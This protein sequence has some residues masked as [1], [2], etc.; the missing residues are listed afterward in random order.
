MFIKNQLIKREFVR[1]DE[2]SIVKGSWIRITI[3]GYP[4]VF[5]C[6]KLEFGIEYICFTLDILHGLETLVSFREEDSL[7]PVIGRIIEVFKTRSYK[8]TD[9]DTRDSRFVTS[10]ISEELGEIF[11][12]HNIFTNNDRYGH[13]S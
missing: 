9:Y 11:K 5:I 2:I 12:G 13:R 3:P 7:F 4:S 1:W 10:L 6:F 8:A